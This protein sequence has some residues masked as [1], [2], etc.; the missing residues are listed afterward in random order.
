MKEIPGT[1]EKFRRYIDHLR[2]KYRRRPAFI[3]EIKGI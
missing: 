1:P 2:E 3:D